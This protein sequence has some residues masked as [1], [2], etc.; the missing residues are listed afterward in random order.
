MI[1]ELRIVVISLMA[2][3]RATALF[4]ALRAIYEEEGVEEAD[5][6][7]KVDSFFD[8]FC[9]GCSCV[10]TFL[11]PSES[12]EIAL[13]ALFTID[14]HWNPQKYGDMDVVKSVFDT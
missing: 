13:D 3:I 10:T 11:I 4:D 5:R 14:I 9:A 6:R 1:N 8:G 12:V 2:P 7:K